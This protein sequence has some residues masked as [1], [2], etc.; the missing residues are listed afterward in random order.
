MDA[1]RGTRPC[2]TP[3]GEWTSSAQKVGG[4]VLPSGRARVS[5]FHSPLLR[6]VLKRALPPRARE[7][8]GVMHVKAFVFDDTV[9]LTGSNVSNNYFT[10]R[11]DRYMVI[12]DAKVLGD[13]LA[14]AVDTIAQF[15]YPL[16]L[17]DADRRPGPESNNNMV[18]LGKSPSGFDPVH[19]AWAFSWQLR[20]RL[21]EGFVPLGADRKGVG[22]ELFRKAFPL[23]DLEQQ[24]RRRSR[25]AAGED[26]TPAKHG[27]NLANAVHQTEEPKSMA[28][29]N[30]HSMSRDASPRQQS[31]WKK[32]RDRL[33][34][35]SEQTRVDWSSADTWLFPT[36]QAGFA[37]LR[38]DETA[39]LALLRHAARHGGV[40]RCSSPYLNLSRSYENALTSVRGNKLETIELLTSSPEANGFFGSAGLSGHIPLAYSVLEHRTW[41]RL[42]RSNS[43]ANQALSASS[44]VRLGKNRRM[45]EY[46]GKGNREFH[47]KGIWW[48]PKGADAPVITSIGSSNFGRRSLQRDLELQFVVA[49][50]HKGLKSALQAEWNALVSNA[51][52]VD[53]EHFRRPGRRSSLVQHVA[54]RMLRS[55]L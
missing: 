29:H 17:L 7:I 31:E 34:M 47:A 16:H 50:R 5:L 41:R 36:F 15:S 35:S 19:R 24:L 51:A 46:E 22:R 52:V 23:H 8:V 49:T 42:T 30:H 9:V 55:F 14:A 27:I 33:T 54:F 28:K 32:A 45:L 6:G 39:T 26:S 25:A 44:E 43:F 1:L 53:A 11:Q 48:T 2:R 12:R 40:L 37:N 21:M 13:M 3:S 10:N 4:A 38:Q 20:R 18:A